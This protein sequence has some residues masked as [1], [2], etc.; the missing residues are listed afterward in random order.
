MPM[1]LSELMHDELLRRRDTSDPLTSDL[2][3]PFEHQAFAREWT[4]VD[5]LAKF[6]LPFAIPGYQLAKLLGLYPSA[7][8]ASLDQLFAGYTGL[9]QGLRH[10][11]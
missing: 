8:P 10:A 9:A 5:P 4:K 11:Q 2:L 3:A 6:A 1:D 7:S